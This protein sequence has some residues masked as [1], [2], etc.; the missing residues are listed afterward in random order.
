ME[1]VTVGVGSVFLVSLIMLTYQIGIAKAM[2]GN[3]S[4]FF[5]ANAQG[6]TIYINT[7]LRDD[8]LLGLSTEDISALPPQFVLFLKNQTAQKSFYYNHRMN[9]LQ[10]NY[11][12]VGQKI[13]Y[14]G[15]RCWQIAVILNLADDRTRDCSIGNKALLHHVIQSVPDAVG[16]MN[17][18]LV[19]EACNSAFVN[20]LGI[21]SP[22]D[23]V[24]KKLEEVA[25]KEIAEK[26]ASSDRNVLE[27]GR[28]FRNIDEVI[29]DKGQK[30][31][32]EARKFA[33]TDQFT[34]NR[35]LFIIARDITERVHAK[36]KLNQAKNEFRRLSLIDS[37]TG[38]G[39]RRNFDESLECVWQQHVEQQSPLTIMFCDIDDFKKLNDIY[40][41]GEGDKALVAVASAL[42]KSISNTEGGVFRIGGEEFAFLLSETEQSRADLVARRIHDQIAALKL[43]HEGS[44]IK[45]TLTISIGVA[46]IVPQTTDLVV[47]TLE[48]VD[49]A[50]Y[51]A[52]SNGKDQTTYAT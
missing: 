11:T 45:S 46:T 42:E 43:R 4:P 6:E 49:K 48:D 18:N 5:I 8:S 39:N 14:R 2:I 44:L 34:N 36:E 27:T 35:G 10:R 13:W 25:S 16:M 12:F 47:D 29:D 38:I 23:L 41:H 32:I 37:L 19:Y 9:H 24:G 7:S 33:Y 15:K 51:Q 3:L 22:S 20:A 17:E 30:Q 1:F 52:K 50:L 26:F 21:D 28:E 31:W 40:G